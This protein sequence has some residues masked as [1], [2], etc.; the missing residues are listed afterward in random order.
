MKYDP[1]CIKHGTLESVSIL[2]CGFGFTPNVMMIK[3]GFEELKEFCSPLF[4][5]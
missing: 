2:D 3:C 1:S 4:L 5:H